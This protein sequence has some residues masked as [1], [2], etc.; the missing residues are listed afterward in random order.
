[1]HFAFLDYEKAWWLVILEN[2]AMLLAWAFTAYLLS[3]I[4]RRVTKK[5]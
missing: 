3:L 2:L 1:M 5:I 4:L